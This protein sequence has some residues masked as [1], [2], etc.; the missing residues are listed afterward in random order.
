MRSHD[1]GLEIK[2]IPGENA[3]SIVKVSSEGYG[4]GEGGWEWE[5]A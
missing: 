5:G 2:L 1:R 4:M 3:I